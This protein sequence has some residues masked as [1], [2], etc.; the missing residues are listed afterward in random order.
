[1]LAADVQADMHL[2][3]MHLPIAIARTDQ[4][5]LLMGA[6]EGDVGQVPVDG[7]NGHFVEFQSASHQFHFQER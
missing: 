6:G 5:T 7:T 3:V 1:M 2:L 4:G